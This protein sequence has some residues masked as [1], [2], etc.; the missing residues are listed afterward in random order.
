MCKGS[1]HEGAPHPAPEIHFLR[2][3]EGQGGDHHR[4]SRDE[5]V[6]L[7]CMLAGGA[8]EAPL[9][10]GPGFLI[11]KVGVMMPGAWSVSA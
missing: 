4:E 3:A 2:R 10:L 9:A 11:C 7:C 5:C 6:P 8:G 1:G